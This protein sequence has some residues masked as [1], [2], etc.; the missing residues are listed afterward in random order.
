MGLLGSVCTNCGY[1]FPP[2]KDPRV[3][4]AELKRIRAGHSVETRRLA[5][6]KLRERGRASGWHPGAARHRFKGIYGEW[7]DR[8]WG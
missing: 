6:E 5:Y 8:S 3:V 7:P 4:R 2:P 1:P